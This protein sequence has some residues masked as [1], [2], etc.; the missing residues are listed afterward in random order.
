[1][2]STWAFDCRVWQNAMRYNPEGHDVHVMA[3]KL[4]V[5]PPPAPRASPA[6]SNKSM[7]ISVSRR[8]NKRQT[9]WHSL[10]VL[11]KGLWQGLCQ[12][13]FMPDFS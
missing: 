9:Q 11:Q 4:L 8:E 6:H 3:K 13:W 12:I 2:A 7:Q 10:A 1:M 5:T